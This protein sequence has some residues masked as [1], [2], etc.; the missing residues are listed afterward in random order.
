MAL[1]DV[2]EKMGAMGVEVVQS[3][4]ESFAKTLRQDTDKYTKLIK[5]LNIQPE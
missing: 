3:T 5:E 2:R 4:P 1:P